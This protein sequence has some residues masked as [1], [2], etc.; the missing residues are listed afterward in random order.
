M[1]KDRNGEL[2]Q[3]EIKSASEIRKQEDFNEK[4]KHNYEILSNNFH[5]FKMEAREKLHQA[6]KEIADA[7]L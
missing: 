6:R 3:K 2:N 5:H 4:W 1:K 7:Q